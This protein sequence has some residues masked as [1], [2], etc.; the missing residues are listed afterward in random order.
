MISVH[1]LEPNHRALVIVRHDS[2]SFRLIQGVGGAFISANSGVVFA[3]TFPKKT[4]GRAYGF[5]SIGFNTGAALGVGL[6][7]QFAPSV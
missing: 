5:N 2:C 4:P 7:L 1:T 6:G 3:D